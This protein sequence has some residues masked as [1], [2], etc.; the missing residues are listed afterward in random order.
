MILKNI[1]NKETKQK[2]SINF[3]ITLIKIDIEVIRS[4]GSHLQYF[5]HFLLLPS[6][7]I[8]F[9]SPSTTFYSF[10]RFMVLTVMSAT[11]FIRALYITFHYVRNVRIHFPQCCAPGN[12]KIY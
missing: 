10:V 5:L 8:S 11:V 7:P 1:I 12:E 2:E 3:F 9:T 6:F 4:A